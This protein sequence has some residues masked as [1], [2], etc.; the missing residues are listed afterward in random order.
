LREALINAIEHGNLEL[1]SHLRERDD[2]SYLQELRRRSELEPYCSR[3][4]TLCARETRDDVTYVIRDEGPGFN[5][6]SLPDP[7]DPE[8]LLKA[9]GRG[10]LL[11]RAF[12]DE[13]SHNPTGNE[14]TLIKRRSDHG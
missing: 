7:T 9:S 11:I 14:I 2:D 12:M 6:S 3:R 1:S 8:N 4:V 10:L 5:V 13:V